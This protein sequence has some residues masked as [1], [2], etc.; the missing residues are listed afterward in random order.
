[1]SFDP[2]AFKSQFPLFAQPDNQSLVYLDNAATTQKPQCVLDAMNNFYL[3]ANGNAQR[4]SHRLARSATHILETVRQQAA[5]FLGVGSAHEVVFT[6]G[7]TEALN[8]VAYGLSCFLEAD[9]RV[10][11]SNVEHH[12]NLLPWQRLA[13]DSESEL[14]FFPEAQGVPQWHRWQ[15]VV[16]KKTRVIAISA[17]SNVTGSLTDL[18]IIAD[19]KQHYPEV[20]VVVDASQLACHQPIKAQQWGCDFLVCS[21]H[22]FYG[23]TG[24]GLLC[25]RSDLLP[26]LSPLIVGGEMVDVVDR[27]HSTFLNS[28]HRLE[29]GTA[30]MSAI[31]GLGAILTFWQ[32]QDRQAMAMYESELLTYLHHQLIQ[33]TSEFLHVVTAP[34]NNVG[35]ATLVPKHHQHSLSDL[36][37]YLD[38]QDIAV[39]VGNHCAQP[40]WQSFDAVYGVAKGL[41]VSIAAYNTRDDIDSLIK[42]INAFF[43]DVS[44]TTNGEMA[45][46]QGD[47]LS[48]LEWESLLDLPWQ[49]RYKTLLRWGSRIS[50]KQNIRH[51]EYQV[52]GCESLVW[53]QHRQ[54][55]GLHYFD[56]DSDSN[57]IKGLAVLLLVWVNGKTVQE[58]ESIDFSNRYRQLGFEKYLSQ[59][60]VNGFKA[61]LDAVTDSLSDT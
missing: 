18:S 13:G 20:I 26:R 1:M 4:S 2:F 41:R 44:D 23:P 5:E 30:S 10:V 60:R 17:A 22:K 57:V 32:Q 56:I 28:V 48:G 36:A 34:Q 33:H 61:L 15:E 50:K 21:A 55:Q 12:A 31:A 58:I 16:N 37:D 7:A 59:S 49:K 19:I 9:D 42:A 40:L 54:C 51:E 11:V 52:K 46:N 8:T 14:C 43:V 45:F 39:R 3:C 27:Q 53:F 29:A 47:D 6:H 25:V 38:H 24:V 35:I